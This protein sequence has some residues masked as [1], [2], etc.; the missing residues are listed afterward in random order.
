TRKR[1]MSVKDGKAVVATVK[2]NG[3]LGSES[4]TNADTLLGNLKDSGNSSANYDSRVPTQATEDVDVG[5]SSMEA[6]AMFERIDEAEDAEVTTTEGVAGIFSSLLGTGRGKSRK[7]N[8]PQDRKAR[9]TR[10]RGRRLSTQTSI[11][12]ARNAAKTD[13]ARRIYNFL[14]KL[15]PTLKRLGYNI[16][17]HKDAE[18]LANALIADGMTE[19]EALAMAYDSDGLFDSQGK[20]IHVRE[21][22]DAVATLHEAMH[23]MFA[24]MASETP[25]ALRNLMDYILADPYLGGRYFASFAARYGNRSITE[26]FEEAVVEFFAQE[27]F[28]R[29]SEDV[30]LNN[31]PT[32]LQKIQDL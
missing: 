21:D 12:N 29:M 14:A 16:V 22:I 23:P 17:V 3:E 7:S 19:Q 32:L 5:L 20:T 18:S 31:D 4:T 8:R 10:I 9:N 30:R 27:L 1:V 13:N 11:V 2:K 25:T 24:Y 26:Q 28:G 6:E 15:R